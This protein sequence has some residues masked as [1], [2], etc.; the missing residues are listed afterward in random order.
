MEPIKHHGDIKSHGKSV[1]VKENQ[2]V[3]P[4]IV[5]CFNIEKEKVRRRLNL[6]KL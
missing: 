5:E 1:M 6:K 3:K 2:I 4:P